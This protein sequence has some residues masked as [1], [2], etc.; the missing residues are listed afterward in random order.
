[1]CFLQLYQLLAA[2]YTASQVSYIP[3]AMSQGALMA[4]QAVPI[5]LCEW[6]KCWLR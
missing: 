3:S 6:E 4:R 1:M 2:I 5:C